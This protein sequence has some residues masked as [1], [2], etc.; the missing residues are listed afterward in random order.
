MTEQLG[1]SRRK[2][3]THA[4]FDHRIAAARNGWPII[5]THHKKGC[6]NWPRIAG[7]VTAIET[8]AEWR[9]LKWDGTGVR[10]EGQLAVYDSDITIAEISDLV[11]DDFFE[12]DPEAFNSAVMRDSGAVTQALF[13]RTEL[14]F[15]HHKTHSYTAHPEVLSELAA[16]YAMPERDGDEH[17]ARLTAIR[18]ATAKLEPQKLE[19]YGPLSKGRHFQYE[20]EHSPGRDYH[21]GDRAPWNTKVSDL[22]LLPLGPGP[23]IDRAN[24]VLAKH[25][26]LI[27]EPQDTGGEVSYD[28][29]D[30]TEFY[31]KDADMATIG[32][33][34]PGLAMGAEHG[35]YGCLASTLSGSK[36]SANCKLYR[37]ITGRI[38]VVNWAK[39]G[40]RHYMESEAPQPPVELSDETRAVLAAL[41][42]E[43]ASESQSTEAPDT[44]ETPP[45]ASVRM[46]EIDR[47]IFGE[48][49][50]DHAVDWLLGNIAYYGSA[51]NG[52]GGGGIVSIHPDGEFYKPVSLMTLRLSMVKYGYD[53]IGPRGGVTRVNPVDTWLARPEQIEVHGIRMRPELERPIFREDGL[54]YLNRYQAPVHPGS[55]GTIAPF[56]TR[57]RGLL[58]ED[59]ER[60]WFMNWARLLVQ[61][62]HWRMVAVAMIARDNGAGRGLLAQTL[63]MVLGEKFVVSMPYANI[64]GGSKF[65]AEVEGRLLLHVNEAA[66]IEAHKW[67]GRNAARE[68]LKDFVEPNHEVPFRVEPKGVDAYFTRAAVSTLIFSNHISGLPL[69]D[70]DRRFAVLMN[71][72]QMSAEQIADYRA[73]MAV[74]AN[75]GALYRYLRDSAVEQDRSVF[76]PYMA[77]MFRGRELMIEAGKTA[78]DHAWE[79]AVAKLETA[80]ELYC[81]SQ[82]VTLTRFMAQ[83]RN[84]DYDDM[85]KKHTFAQGHRIGVKR[86]KE[87]NWKTRYGSGDDN[88]EPVFAFSDEAARKWTK[89]D[90]REIKQQLDKAQAVI[91]APTKAFNK[92]LHSVKLAE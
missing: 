32:E 68:A 58:V 8:L 57:M 42:P 59:D 22:P 69:D 85:V 92:L 41:Q 86:P 10:V 48:A 16:A 47:T 21:C 89:A 63:Q 4:L 40:R 71:G 33:L 20:G 91:D 30:A 39:D 88:R 76:N 61:Q 64:S 14:P 31:P 70:A 50:H 12:V 51:F 81:M 13:F 19:I 82:V 45:R 55:G 9:G 15:R 66:S 79:A 74:P 27:P 17:E 36:S 67:A 38:V 11:L 60:A 75:I 56:E 52:R 77:P 25:L 73:W 44:E 28:L 24:A 26:T 87:Q 49:T 29:T 23:L 18:A 34:A 5:P 7:T 65:N 46:D 54:R 2:R 43:P 80:T 3:N 90:P 37:S 83:T 35:I 84:T 1:G 6:Y 72:P 53:R 78:L 62:P